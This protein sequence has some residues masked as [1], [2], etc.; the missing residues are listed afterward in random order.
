[1]YM[2]T[3]I[4][5]SKACGGKNFLWLTIELGTAGGGYVDLKF[6]VES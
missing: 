2:I 4:E 6:P 3:W 1:M 5:N